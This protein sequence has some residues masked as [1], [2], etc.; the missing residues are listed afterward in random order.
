MLLVLAALAACDD[1]AEVDVAASPAP[2]AGLGP[3]GRGGG[4]PGDPLWA[5]YFPR[6]TGDY[7]VDPNTETRAYGERAGA[8]LEDACR[9]LLDGECDLYQDYGLRRVVSLRYV[10]RRGS[11]G[12]VSVTLSRFGAREA[13]YGFFTH[14][15]LEDQ[16]PARSTAE[17]F[18]AVGAGALGDRGAYVW[19]GEHVA[20]LSYAN[21]LQAPA[22][23]RDTSRRVLP[24]LAK[25]LSERLAGPASPPEAVQ[26]LPETHRLKL[27]IRY[28]H[29]DVL[30]VSGVGEGAVG[31]YRN[32][33]RRYRIFVLVRPDEDAAEDVVKT[34]KRLDG[35]RALK[36]MPFGVLRVPRQ[37]G[38]GA[39]WVE[40]L[41]S[42]RGSRVYGVGDEEL[43]LS[44]LS[45]DQ[46][47]RVCLDDAEKVAVLKKLVLGGAGSP[48]GQ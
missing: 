30:G 25:A 40:W 6:V 47:K 4:R 22:R 20:E 24:P 15:V 32:G 36:D 34:L 19:R 33:E 8:T 7:C 29:R 17:A 11:D 43:V 35:A 38:E 13:A 41:V 1:P 10:G 28:D 42:H 27:G 26:R 16:D 31:F 46:R 14:R 5:D 12:A 23:L 18:A 2:S 39:P 48:V 37:A 3:C 9:E 21:D 44:G 45:P